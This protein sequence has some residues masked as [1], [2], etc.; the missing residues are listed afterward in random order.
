MGVYIVLGMLIGIGLGYGLF[1]F[2]YEHRQVIDELRA[3][4]TKVQDERDHLRMELQE[5]T[6][7]NKILK[8]KAQM[9]L[10]QNEDYAKVVSELSRY[11]YILRKWNE[12]LK[13]LGQ[14][15]GSYEWD[16]ES[17]IEKVLAAPHI[18]AEW[19]QTD[20]GKKFF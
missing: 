17:K 2:R 4:F 12:K 6:E 14:V 18:S 20:L 16:I 3:N 10:D 11:Y 15:L 7:Q 19:L 13:E 9:L 1:Y 8:S 5:Y